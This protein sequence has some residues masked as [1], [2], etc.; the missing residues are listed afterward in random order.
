M[1]ETGPE[2][3]LAGGSCHPEDARSS[4][5][6]GFDGEPYPLPVLPLPAVPSAAV[7]PRAVSRPGVP[8]QIPPPARSAT[9][10]VVSP[11]A[12]AGA[13]TALAIGHEI[14]DKVR[15]AHSAVLLTHEAINDRLL[16]L[17]AGGAKG[18]MAA[19]PQSLLSMSTTRPPVRPA[20]APP[21]DACGGEPM[22]VELVQEVPADSAYSVDGQASLVSV[23]STAAAAVSSLGGRGLAPVG[24]VYRPGRTDLSWH[25]DLPAA[26]TE[27]R[28]RADAEVLGR[29]ERGTRFAFTWQ[30]R[31]DGRLLAEATGAAGFLL[32]AHAAEPLPEPARWPDRRVPEYPRQFRP[33][34]TTHRTQLSWQELRA[35]T[36]GYLADVLGPDFDFTDTALRLPEQAARLVHAVA[37][38]APDSG[39]YAQGRLIAS[40]VLQRGGAPG[41]VDAT[42]LLA[43]AAAGVLQTYALHRGLHLCLPNSRFQP[44]DG[45]P[46]TIEVLDPTA[47]GGTLRYEV[48]V[49]E[50]GLVPRPY[51]LADAVVL[52][53]DHPV[54]RL[55]GFGVLVRERPGTD[56]TL[57]AWR[58]DPGPPPPHTALEQPP[59]VQRF[60]HAHCSEGD[61]TMITGKSAGITA[62]I[63]PRL[64]RGDLLMV[65]RALD[66]DGEPLA[67]SPGATLT[68]EYRVHK[69]P[70]YCRENGTGTVPNLLYM[71]TSLQAAAQLSAA[72]GVVFTYPGSTLVCRNLE[73]RATLLRQADPRGHPLRHRTTLITHSPLPGAILHRYGY[74]LTL[75]D[76]PVYTG[77]S[78]HGFFTQEALDKQQGLD[79]GRFVPPWLHRQPVRP[80]GLRRLDLTGDDRLGRGRLALLREAELLPEG[81]EHGAGY[82]LWERPVPKDDW[83]MA[84]H[85]LNDPVMPG[86]VGVES[87]FQS[88]SAFA[89]ATP[90]AEEVPDPILRPAAGVELAWKYRGQIRPEHQAMRGEVH[91]RQVRRTA[92]GLVVIADGSIWR[93]RLR[94]YQV[95]NLA[96]EILPG[97]GAA[98]RVGGGSSG[99]HAA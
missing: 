69:D 29:D 40:V 17:H 75:P 82:L 22:S 93:D 51:L 70:W 43:E 28:V 86:S 92:N 27:L 59:G 24:S 2:A 5:R 7:P 19:L 26:G 83:F 33:P 12:G 73:G 63:R 66:Y 84:H 61:L 38:I 99:D 54:A 85:F 97:D 78:V 32:P 11:A 39:R 71:E 46:S 95:D 67:F 87:L 60:H 4:E 18:P 77:E 81:G 76:G 96:V 30:I 58:P 21:F 14:A 41:G 56:I 80:P 68:S 94:I 88:V 44:W 89:L 47:L 23:L 16:A 10:R 3:P 57:A 79:G 35:L 62:P 45:C 9:Q 15:R 72:Q 91:I 13:P 31:A 36:S 42:A 90:L 37:D 74:E 65:D 98:E 25:G 1:V 53:G 50:L 64:P 8:P 20:T 48:E 34:A 6:L 52:A 49:V 55:H